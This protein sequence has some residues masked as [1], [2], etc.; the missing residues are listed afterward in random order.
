REKGLHII[1]PLI[2]GTLENIIS[3]GTKKALTGPVARGDSRTVES[4][5]KAIL[6]TIPEMDAF[7]TTMCR[8]TV[9]IA[10]EAG[11]I[12]ENEAQ[13]ICKAVE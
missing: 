2:N 7:Y 4:H 9:K 5:R 13:N 10:E 6:E 12:K 8:H 1:T 11:Y 3:K